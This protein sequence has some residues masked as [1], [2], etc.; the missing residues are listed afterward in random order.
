MRKPAKALQTEASTD[1]CSKENVIGFTS[2]FMI[3]I[4]NPATIL[5]FLFAFSTFDIAENLN[6]FEA[7]M[8]VLGVLTGAI[9]WWVALAA[10]ANKFKEKIKDKT[11]RILNLA[12]GGIMIVLALVMFIKPF[13]QGNV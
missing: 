7:T 1:L 2:A 4:T 5:A 9:I 13:I 3:S 11:N 6:L 10:L 12:C 8:L